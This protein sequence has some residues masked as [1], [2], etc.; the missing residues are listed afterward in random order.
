MTPRLTGGALL[1]RALAA[2]GVTDLF[3]V[4]AGKLGPFAKAVAEDGRFR[5]VGTRHEAAAAWMATASFHGTGRIAACFGECGPGSLNLVSGLG[6]AFNDNL[7]VLALTTGNPS[8][9]TYPF[10]GMFMDLD[11]RQA[12]S[13]VTKWR[14]TAANAAD[15]PNLVHTALREALSGAPGPVQIELPA[16]LLAAEAAVD[17]SAVELTLAAILPPPPEPDG[18]AIAHAAALLRAAER[19]VVVAG[20]GTVHSGAAAEVRALVDR[21]G[22]AA[23]STQMALGV[24]PSDDPRFVGHGGIVGGEGVIRALTEADVVVA[25]GCRFSSWLWEGSR[26]L[27]GSQQRLV[28]IDVDASRIGALV[29]ADVRIVGDA[30]STVA[31]LLEA[32][33]DGEP[34]DTA[35]WIASLVASHRSHVASLTPEDAG[36]PLHPGVA[37]AA[38]AA[39][40]PDGALVVYDG[41]HTTFWS[42]DLIPATGPRTR[43]HEPGMAHLGFGL[44]YAL[45]LQLLHPERPVVNVTGDGAFGFTIAELDTARR[46][47]LPVVTVVMNNAAWGVIGFGQRRQGFELG[48]ALEGTRYAEIARAFGC[49]GEEVVTADGIGHALERALAS[50]SPAVLDVR[51]RFEPHPSLPRFAG[52]GR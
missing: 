51:V 22:A 4:P 41:G 28:H 26:P 50:G 42:N 10:R 38:L 17:A 25:V 12:F 29:P 20:G 8:Q 3:G 39:A 36:E 14:A 47:G 11:E 19:P 13:A 7:A 45:A 21:L 23:T 9:L 34:A 6:S 48:T 32:L 31:A 24:V 35:G 5:V 49:H 43:F 30:R 46:Y 40:L 1:A 15:F 44:P 37:T 52:I 16:D 2:A 27:G 33:G 18:T